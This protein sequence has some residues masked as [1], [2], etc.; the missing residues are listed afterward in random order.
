MH[1]KCI[2]IN[3]FLRK[4]NIFNVIAAEL[5]RHL[6]WWLDTCGEIFREVNYIKLITKHAIKMT[7]LTIKIERI[8]KYWRF[9]YFH[10]TFLCLSNYLIA[11]STS[12]TCY[13]KTYYFFRL[14]QSTR[15]AKMCYFETLEKLFYRS[16]MADYLENFVHDF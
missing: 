10:C 8:Q 7:N 12:H 3:G 13:L 6:K 2:K 15:F 11:T 9:V 14:L 1:N 5:L 16:T 4:S